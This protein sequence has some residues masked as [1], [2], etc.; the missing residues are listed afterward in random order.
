VKHLAVYGVV[1][2][3]DLSAGRGFFIGSADF[4]SQILPP[5]ELRW[6]RPTP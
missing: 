6:H 1:C 5:Q 2:G 4:G 3:T